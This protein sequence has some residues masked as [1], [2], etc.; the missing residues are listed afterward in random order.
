[1]LLIP[2]ITA[3]DGRVLFAVR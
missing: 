3:D 1:V 2:L